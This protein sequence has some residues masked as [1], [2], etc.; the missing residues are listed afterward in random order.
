MNFRSCAYLAVLLAL[1]LLPA[2]CDK[3]VPARDTDAELAELMDRH[4]LPSL[5]ACVVKGDAMAWSLYDGHADLE[6]GRMADDQT[7]YHIASVSKL[8][9]VTAVMQLAEDGL[10]DLDR[11]V[12]AYLPYAFRHPDHPGTPI[13][14]EMLL[15]HTAGLAWPK[16]YD[17][18]QGMWNQH[19][20][21]QGPPPSEWVPQFLV[22]AGDHY[23]P[24]LWKPVA[25][26]TH[27]FYSNLGTCVAA[28]I[29]ETVS[30]MN[31]RD[32]CQDHIF[33]PLGMQR[34]SYWYGGL[35]WDRMARLYDRQHCRSEYFDNRIY[36]SGGA[37]TTI[38]DLARFVS[39]ILNRG[40]LDGTE[41]LSA[42]SVDQMLTL[43]NPASGRCLAWKAYLGGWY[44]HTGGLDRGAATTLALHPESRTG[45]L[46][47]TNTQSAAVHQGGDIFWL[48]RQHA[49]SL[50]D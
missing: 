40:S 33:G 38:P 8:F 39:C 30:G 49:N 1:P 19:D 5:A 50:M 44:G 45:F 18:Q 12:S 13:T 29:V 42:A 36:P 43:R 21:D 10:L 24:A 16:S 22:H 27:E 34:T 47:F 23:D 31:F 32:Y 3:E 14:L 15:N 46:I 37:K 7:I 48:I 25:P 26:G 20:P 35:D 17:S 6:E 9:I 41:V 2:G 11:D 28:C 4:R